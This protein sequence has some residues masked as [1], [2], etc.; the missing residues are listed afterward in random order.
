MLKKPFI[1]WSVPQ[2]EYGSALEDRFPPRQIPASKE[3]VLLIEQTQKSAGQKGAVVLGVGD[4]VKTGQK[5]VRSGGQAAYVISPVTGKVISTALHLGDFGRVYTAITIEVSKEELFDERFS[6]ISKEPALE[7]AKNFLM[8]IPGKPP[9]SPFFDPDHSIHT[10]VVS[11]A[12]ADLMI[13]TNRNI[14]THRMED[15]L[16]GIQVLKTITG[17][18]RMIL[19]VPENFLQGYGTIGAEIRTVPLTYPSAFPHLMMQN[20]LGQTVPAGKS[21][22]DMGVSFFTAEAAASLGVAFTKGRIPTNKL[23]TVTQKNGSQIM[24]ETRIGTPL[25]HV[26]T[27]LGIDVQDKDRIIHGGPMTGTALFSEKAPVLPDTDG[28]MV[29]ASADVALTSDDPCINC[30][31]CVRVCPAKIPVNMLVR[32]LEAGQ[33]EEAADLYDLHCCIECGLCSYV[34]VSRMPI[35]QYIRLGKYELG[36]MNDMETNHA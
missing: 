7:S 14:L 19:A 23:L 18:P 29:Q 25:G 17:V 9:L 6:S 33:Y 21:S 36:R 11:G 26:L 32:F 5:I 30:G 3:I 31:E 20:I 27:S 15:V 16:K 2:F 8:D 22:E 28:I 1:G 10:I 34:C 12:D 4:E 24:V 35:F 13:R